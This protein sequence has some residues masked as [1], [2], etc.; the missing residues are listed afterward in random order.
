MATN[1]LWRNKGE[2]QNDDVSERDDPYAGVDDVSQG[3][4]HGDDF[5]QA[6]S[7]PAKDG[8]VETS[9]MAAYRTLLPTRRVRVYGDDIALVSY[10]W[11]ITIWMHALASL[12]LP[13]RCVSWDLFREM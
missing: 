10:R 4:G 9:Q 6:P 11:T 8:V 2:R 12:S 5:A 1:R 3:Q 7:T 13:S